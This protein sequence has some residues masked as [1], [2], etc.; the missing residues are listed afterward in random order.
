ME[1]WIL[2]S[3]NPVTGFTYYGPFESAKQ[4]EEYSENTYFDD[5]CW[6]VRLEK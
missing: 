3:G 1:T 4:A 6:W 5:E 2:I